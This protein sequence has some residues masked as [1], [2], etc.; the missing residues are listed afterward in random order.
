MSR[1]YKKHLYEKQQNTKGLKK[2]A[3]RRVRRAKNVPSGKAYKKLFQSWDIC[4]WRWYTSKEEAVVDYYESTYLQ[5]RF[6]TLEKY[7]IYW[8][9]C[10]KRK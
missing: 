3:N 8:E 9:K 2:C 5:D 7:L 10:V 4:D 1:S 6:E